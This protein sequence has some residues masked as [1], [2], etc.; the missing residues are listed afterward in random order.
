MKIC[1]I[2][3][4]SFPNGFQYCPNDTELLLTQED[5]QRVVVPPS[6]E[7]V[8]EVS[9]E[10]RPASSR[11]TVD[12]RNSGVVTG[13][14]ESL[15][16]VSAPI[17]S[18]VK[19]PLPS[20]PLPPGRVGASGRLPTGRTARISTN[21]DPQPSEPKVTK[22]VVVPASSPVLPPAQ[23]V[24]GELNFIMP[25]GGSLIS[26]LTAVLRNIG[27]IL[28]KPAAGSTTGTGF[29]FLLAEESLS[30]RISREFS[31]AGE[32]FRRDP[33]RFIV[34]LT[35]GEGSNL[36][37]RNMLLAGSEMAVVGFVTAYFALTALSSATRSES[38]TARW[39]FIAF[40]AYIAGCYLIRGMLLLR[41]IN[42][43]TNKLIGPK[44]AL[45][46]A[47]WLPLV[48]I[49]ILSV[50]LSNYNF[51]CS[52]FPGRCVPP[53]VVVDE[54]ALLTPLTDVP[55]DI[56][57]KVEKSAA[58]K[59][60]KIGGSLKR[61]KAASGGGGGGRSQPTPPSKGVPPPMALT[62]QIVMPNPEPPKIKNPSLAVVPTIYG[63]PRALPPMKGPIGDPGGVP[64]PPSSGPGTGAGIGRG[65]GTG[66]GTG[67][68]GGAGAGRGG[69]TG[70]GD[71]GLGGGRSVEPMSASL[72]PTILY[73]EKA[74]YTEEARQNKVQGTVVLNVVFTSDAR[75]TSIKVV[76]G[77]PDGLTEKAIEAAQ[78]I[79]FNPAVK[80][81]VPV[82]VRGNLEFTFNLY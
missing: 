10:P 21:S 49:L 1:P 59:E 28:Q 41:L 2:C 55:T 80:G 43:A 31:A 19:P 53:E 38:L 50:V 48:V 22:S 9:T 4:Q 56:K 51:Y 34:E 39:L 15:P 6:P 30:T 36:R 40:I 44:I 25:E 23:P 70:G 57:V 62:P 66:V 52:L 26:R 45:E 81:G 29:Q 27:E 8:R 13:Q 37:R 64:G 14:T 18:P 33:R 16:P 76:R 58:V 61:P 20:S 82:S 74:K 72:R 69:N 46:I 5:Y 79:R 73:K 54:L 63:D 17:P 11:E 47:N 78:R 3:Q 42:R 77:L 7:P 68:G 75:I 71:M 35:R 67:E 65:S 24:V 60:R 12:L 32:E